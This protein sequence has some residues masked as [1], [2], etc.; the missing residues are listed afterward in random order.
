LLAGEIRSAAAI[1]MARVLGA[2][3]KAIAC[4]TIVKTEKISAA[5]GLRP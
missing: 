1:G 5:G 2:P 4:V 3:H